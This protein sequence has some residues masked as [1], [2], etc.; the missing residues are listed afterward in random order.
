MSSLQAAQE[1]KKRRLLASTAAVGKAAA[2]AIAAGTTADIPAEPVRSKARRR[3]KAARSEQPQETPGHAR[4][5]R[6]P[7]QKLEDTG[8]RGLHSMV[9]YRD[10]KQAGIVDNYETLRVLI[11]ERGFPQGCWPSPNVHLWS[12]TEVNQWLDSLPKHRPELREPDDDA[13]QLGV[14]P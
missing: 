12:V 5:A 6:G 13:P 3:R 1:A 8:V 2:K 10:L 7:P 4:P 14:V 9:R 11:T